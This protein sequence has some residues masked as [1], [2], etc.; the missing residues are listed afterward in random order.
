VGKEQRVSALGGADAGEYKRTRQGIVLHKVVFKAK[1]PG[2]NTRDFLYPSSS[3]PRS[4]IARKSMSEAVTTDLAA[5][6]ARDRFASGFERSVRPLV[7]GGKTDLKGR[8]VS[9]NHVLADSR[10][11]VILNDIRDVGRTSSY[12]NPDQEA[13]CT[14]FVCSLTG[15]EAGSHLAAELIRNITGKGSLEHF[16]RLMHEICDGR[17]NLRFGLAD[18][19]TAVSNEFDPVIVDG[20]LHPRSQR[21]SDAVRELAHNRLIS[22]EQCFDSLAI[23]RDRATG[24]YVTSNAIKTG[25]DIGSRTAIDHFAPPV[26]FASLPRSYSV[27]LGRAGPSSLAPMP[28]EMFHHPSRPASDAME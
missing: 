3:G 14:E 26:S 13:A 16:A 25:S 10:I 7:E 1:R 21:I 27:D 12:L 28:S 2:R 18:V 15:A 20:R 9:R 23:T 4:A 17:E 19:N 11:R 6:L 5:R 8:N 24:H 22:P